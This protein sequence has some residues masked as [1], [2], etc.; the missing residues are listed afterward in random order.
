GAGFAPEVQARLFEMF[1][2]GAGS[3][4]LGIGLALVRKLVE[5]HGG[6]VEARSEGEGR[7]A[8]FAVTLPLT[9]APLLAAPPA[10][11][12][13]GNGF[14]VLVA[15]DNRDAAES[16]AAL[17]EALG[18]DVTVAYNGIEAVEVAR[19]FRP[20]VI[21][22]DIGMPGLDGYGAARE[23]RRDPGARA[24]K[25]VALTGWGQDED[26]R[27]VREA[28]FDAHIVKPAEL[29]VLRRVLSE[30]NQQ[31]STEIGGSA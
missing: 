5:M 19:S 18:N 20:Q 6:T 15:D 7:G 21:L 24:I 22:L 27:R 26:R 30:V 17:L 25:I 10:G 31:P 3:S 12:L 29:D 11:M 16:L 28:G 1:S 13:R 2:R 9:D 4:G 23:I 8:E 14:R